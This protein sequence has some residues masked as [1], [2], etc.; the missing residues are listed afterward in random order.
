MYAIRSYYAGG[1]PD[2][3]LGQRE[4]RLVRGDDQVASERD[5]ES[6]AHRNAVH[7]GD[8]RLG[9]VVAVGETAEALRRMLWALAG[10]GAQL[11]MVF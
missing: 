5:L 3:R 8:H 2:A 10:L 6:A 11:R 4:G 9:E 1:E 7:R